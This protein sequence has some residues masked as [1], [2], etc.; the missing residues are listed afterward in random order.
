MDRG[1]WWATVHTVAESWSQ[2]KPVSLV[3]MHAGKELWLNEV[4]RGRDVSHYLN[5]GRP[6]E[7]TA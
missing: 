3:S 1:A 6:C 5:P 2:L 4:T 7:A